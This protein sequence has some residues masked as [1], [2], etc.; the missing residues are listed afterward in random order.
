MM[1]YK[2]VARREVRAGCCAAW[3]YP[4]AANSH[5][6]H[7]LIVILFCDDLASVRKS[8]LTDFVGTLSPA[9]L[10]ALSRALKIALD[11]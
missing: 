5:W 6:H 11:I 10:S 3:G 7:R 2:I 9:K 1:R 4:L 8:H